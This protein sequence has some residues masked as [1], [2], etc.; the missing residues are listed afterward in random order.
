MTLPMRNL[1]RDAGQEAECG[2][3]VFARFG[4]CVLAYL[5]VCVI[6]FSIQDSYIFPGGGDAGATGCVAETGI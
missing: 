3:G 2:D 6:M 4:L 5:G 1:D